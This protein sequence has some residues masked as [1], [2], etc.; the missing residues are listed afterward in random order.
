MMPSSSASH[1]ATVGGIGGWE[2]P[3]VVAEAVGAAEDAAVVAAPRSLLLLLTL[4]PV[5]LV[6]AL[7]GLDDTEVSLVELGL[8]SVVLAAAV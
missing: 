5:L 6:S 2:E 7:V 8:L 3:N 1:S 4:V